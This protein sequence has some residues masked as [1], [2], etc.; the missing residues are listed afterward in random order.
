MITTHNLPNNIATDIVEQ[1]K[2]KTTLRISEEYSSD[3][4]IE[5]L[6]HQLYASN[7]LTPSLVV[8]S[9][10]MGDLKFLNMRWF[11]FPTLRCWKSANIV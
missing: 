3:K 8:R 5:E 2:E 4:Q 10:C 7:H 6:V 11:T 9:I 1:V